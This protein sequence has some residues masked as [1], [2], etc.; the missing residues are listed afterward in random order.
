MS[1][2]RI[3]LDTN[4]LISAIVFGGKPREVLEKVI[5]GWST[6]AISAEMLAEF[7]WVFEGEKFRYPA[8]IVRNILRELLAV[9]ELVRSAMKV[10][11]IKADPADNRILE[12]A[13]ESRAAYIVS[14][15]K[16]L[17]ELG[18]FEGIPILDAAEFLAR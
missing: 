7:Q 16:H 1:A 14:G 11:H 17:L 5:A 9:S 12:C 8:A 6:M 4:V 18:Q 10:E 2:P 15:D 13:L 3:V